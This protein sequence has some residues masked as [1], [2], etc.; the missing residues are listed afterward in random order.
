MSTKSKPLGLALVLIAL[1]CGGVAFLGGTS[2]DGPVASASGPCDTLWT[3]LMTE[4]GSVM[5]ASV[6][7]S[8]IAS[9]NVMYGA[10]AISDT[11]TYNAELDFFTENIALFKEGLFLSIAEEIAV[12]TALSALTQCV[13]SSSVLSWHSTEVQSEEQFMK[14]KDRKK[15]TCKPSS[16]N[17]CVHK[18][19]V[20][21]NG[22]VVKG[23][24]SE[25]R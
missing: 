22:V 8:F 5:D 16:P 15:N 12:Y 7:S 25:T 2:G 23:P 17:W 6:E 3:D 9:C 1:V 20:D 10:H 19:N 24:W 14:R 21:E 13:Q 4:I 11:S 18:Q